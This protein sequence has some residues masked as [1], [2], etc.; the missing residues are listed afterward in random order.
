MSSELSEADTR[1]AHIDPIL[2][3]LNY[4]LVESIKQN[5]I[6]LEHKNR[7]YVVFPK[8][9]AHGAPLLVIETKKYS[10]E[11]KLKDGYPDISEGTTKSLVD[12]SFGYAE[13]AGIPWIL[14]RASAPC[15]RIGMSHS[16]Y[17]SSSSYL[18]NSSMLVDI[19]ITRAD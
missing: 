7:D 9:E 18:S 2:N 14:A 12:Q 19:S 10:T 4:E 6:R 15:F 1:V 3:S 11:I 8:G 17:G 5:F 13:D 16:S